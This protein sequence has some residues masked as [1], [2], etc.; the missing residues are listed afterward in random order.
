MSDNFHLH[1]QH[2]FLRP[3]EP[4]DIYYIYTGLSN[5]HITK[6]YGV[7]FNSLEATEAQM[8]W[9]EELRKN[10]TGIWWAIIDKKQQQF[11]GAVGF[12]NLSEKHH[13]AEIGCWLFPEYWGKGVMQEIFPLVCEFGFQKLQ[14]HRIEGFVESENQA[15]KKAMAK[16]PFQFE[17]TMKDC[18]IKNGRYISLDIYAYIAPE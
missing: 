13:K 15:C 16:L 2:Y 8:R 17:G 7:H 14:L 3:I 9:Y 5:P 18:E 11:T 1:T 10:N 6:Y 12:N 4:S